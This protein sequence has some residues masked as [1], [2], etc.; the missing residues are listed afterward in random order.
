VSPAYG[1]R[2]AARSAVT[3]GPSASASLRPSAFSALIS[4]ILSPLPL[5]TPRTLPHLEGHDPLHRVTSNARLCCNAQEV[6][7]WWQILQRNLRAEPVR[8]R[9]PRRVDRAAILRLKDWS[10]IL[11]ILH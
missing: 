6:S 1:R 10:P 4:L 5:L 7:P 11:R 8:E 2:H 3:R 9:T